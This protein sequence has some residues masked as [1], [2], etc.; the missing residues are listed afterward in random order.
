[1]EKSV[2]K[3]DCYSWSERELAQIIRK[4]MT[5]KSRRNKKKFN[6]NNN[7]RD[8]RKEVSYF[9]FIKFLKFF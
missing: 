9:L 5:T 2:V 6:R 7:K 4:K 8:F 3:I 1:M